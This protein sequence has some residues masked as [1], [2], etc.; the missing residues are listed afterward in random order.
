MIS[1]VYSCGPLLEK[2]ANACFKVKFGG[3][4]DFQENVELGATENETAKSLV[5]KIILRMVALTLKASF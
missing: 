5:V 3:K 4:K 1:H 2:V